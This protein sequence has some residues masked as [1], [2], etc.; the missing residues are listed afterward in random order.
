MAKEHIVYQGPLG[1]Q[2][3]NSEDPRHFVLY[4]D[5]LDYYKNQADFEDGQKPRGSLVNSDILVVEADDRSMFL[6]LQETTVQINTSSPELTALWVKALRWVLECDITFNGQPVE[7]SDATDGESSAGTSSRKSGKSAGSSAESKAEEEAAATAE[8]R[9]K[10]TLIKSMAT[11]AELDGDQAGGIILC[12]SYLTLTRKGTTSR[13]YFALLKEHFRYWEKQE[14]SDERKAPRGNIQLKDVASF[15]VLDKGFALTLRQESKRLEFNTEE[16]EDKGLWH[17]SWRSVLGENLGSNF[18]EL[19]D[20]PAPPSSTPSTPTTAA[21]PTAT[22]S[23]TSTA[24]ATRAPSSKKLEPEGE[25]EVAEHTAGTASETPSSTGGAEAPVARKRSSQPQPKRTSRSASRRGSNGGSGSGSGSAAGGGGTPRGSKTTT[26]R[27]ASSR[28]LQRGESKVSFGPP[29][30][31]A[32]ETATPRSSPSPSGSPR[33]S[34]NPSP[35]GKDPRPSHCKGVMTILKKKAKDDTRFFVMFGDCVEYYSTE[36]DFLQKAKPRGFIAHCDVEAVQVGE[37]GVMAMTVSG[38]SFQLKCDSGEE[39]ARWG[40]TWEVVLK[41]PEAQNNNAVKVTYV[42]SIPIKRGSDAAPF[43]S[44]DEMA[45][46]ASSTRIAVGELTGSDKDFSP[47]AIKSGLSRGDTIEN[48]VRDSSPEPAPKAKPA[49]RAEP[50]KATVAVRAD[51]PPNPALKG[52]RK[53]LYK[54]ALTLIPKIKERDLKEKQERIAAQAR[55]ARAKARDRQLNSARGRE[56]SAPAAPVAT[57]TCSPGACTSSKFSQVPRCAM[58]TRKVDGTGSLPGAGVVLGAHIVPDSHA[59]RSSSA[60]LGRRPDLKARGIYINTH[61]LGLNAHENIHRDAFSE[62]TSKIGNVTTRTP[63]TPRLQPVA[64]H[65]R[66]VGGAV[67]PLKTNGQLT[68]KPNAN[69]GGP[70][71]RTRAMS[72]ESGA[73]LPAKIVGGHERA[74]VPPERGLVG[75]C[76]WQKVNQPRDSP[77]HVLSPRI[78]TPR[79]DVSKKIGETDSIY[80]R[81]V[82]H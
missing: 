13:R 53:L 6:H 29:P 57:R 40:K 26:A 4:E 44:S 16:D 66:T 34:P 68:E 54:T 71:T 17:A 61:R 73:S 39:A 30:T 81:I 7:D 58:V 82:P 52:Y 74:C 9:P 59:I 31:D 49:K 47:K 42:K 65:L 76:P 14:D 8:V 48:F 67:D 21:P 12:E 80:R 37:D 35:A 33:T 32:A 5:R 72:Y 63:T 41:L 55:A 62:D 75:D 27:S 43:S 38:K 25:A 19:D 70:I 51:K 3:R 45:S 78:G 20:T 79:G 23:R 69:L 1:L 60:K 36:E 28:A 46:Q 15:E 2:K 11:W 56:P 64:A 24:T 18:K 10:T 77:V 22:S 50:A